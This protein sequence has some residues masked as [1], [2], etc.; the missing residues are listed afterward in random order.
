MHK[1]NP[2]QYIHI[3]IYNIHITHIYTMYNVFLHVGH[4][5]KSF[6]FT[7][8]WAAPPRPARPV[9]AQLQDGRKSLESVTE[10][11]VV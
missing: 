2:E 1:Y 10:T 6:K 4:G 9:P 3:R 11:S 5:L 7:V 8:C